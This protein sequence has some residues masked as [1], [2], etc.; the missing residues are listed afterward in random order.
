MVTTSL[1][2]NEIEVGGKLVWKLDEACIPVRAALWHYLSEPDEWRLV[3]AS[4]LVDSEGP[5]AVYARIYEAVRGL[6]K[7][8]GI[9]LNDTSVV[10]LNHS[11]IKLLRG[12]IGTGPGVAGTRF[13]RNTINNVYVAD[14]YI[15]RL[16]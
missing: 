2:E 8:G 14:A 15:Y 5:K 4:P 10:S 16:E 12:A 11:L 1:V 3:I 7:C 6:F 9:S 13:S